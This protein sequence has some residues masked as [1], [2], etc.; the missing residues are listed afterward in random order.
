MRSAEAQVQGGG[1]TSGRAR[2][3]TRL[4]R[5]APPLLWL[6][7]AALSLVELWMIAVTL[8]RPAP[9][10]WG[11]RGFGAVLA[12]SFGSVGALIAA[13]RPAHRIG[14]VALGAGGG[15]GAGEVGG[16]VPGRA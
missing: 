9:D 11:F 6:L 1:V 16:P 10:Q 2:V 14:W 8:D 7:I 12:L 3:R 4:V 15:G 5:R 13:R